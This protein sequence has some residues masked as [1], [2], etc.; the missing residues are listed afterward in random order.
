M[1][2]IPL[3]ETSLTICCTKASVCTI[4]DPD[5]LLDGMQAIRMLFCSLTSSRYCANAD[6]SLMLTVSLQQTIFFTNQ[7]IL[8]SDKRGMDHLDM[9]DIR[10]IATSVGSSQD[11]VTELKGHN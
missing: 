11:I 7:Q 4:I 5:W 8:E 2:L 9:H 10:S 1:H 6:M 3:P